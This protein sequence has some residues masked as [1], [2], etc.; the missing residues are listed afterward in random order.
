[1]PTFLRGRSDVDY[2]GFDLL[3]VNIES[4]KKKFSNETWKFNTFDLV[5]DRI[6]KNIFFS[7]YESK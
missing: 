6:G 7:F 1:M 2:T 5:K 3:P 4:A